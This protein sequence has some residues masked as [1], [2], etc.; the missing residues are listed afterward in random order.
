MGPLGGHKFDR[1]F[2]RFEQLNDGPRAPHG[3]GVSLSETRVVGE[4]I[5]VRTIEDVVESIDQQICPQFEQ[6]LRRHLEGHDKEWLIDQIVRLTLDARTSLVP[7]YG[8]VGSEAI[9]DGI[10]AAPSIINGLE[11]NEQ[12]LHAC[13]MNVEHGTLVE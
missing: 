12:I 5:D 6:E 9:G 4:E 7:E 10:V 8:E 13:M 11:I 2:L 3:I 1:C